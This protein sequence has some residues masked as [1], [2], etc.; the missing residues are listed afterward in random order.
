MTYE[1]QANSTRPRSLAG[2]P[3]LAGHTARARRSAFTLFELI[4]A[5][6]LSVALLSLI[7]TAINLYLLQVDASRIAHRRGPTGPQRAG[8]DRRR[9]PRHVDLQAAGHVGHRHA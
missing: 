8:H 1:I 9:S 6:A 5:I 7:G 4:L 3:R 2:E